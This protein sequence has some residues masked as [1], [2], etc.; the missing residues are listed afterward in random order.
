MICCRRGKF[1][2]TARNIEIR[3]SAYSQS[4]GK[5]RSLPSL[6]LGHACNLAIAECIDEKL[7]I[8]PCLVT[9][10]MRKIHKEALELDSIFSD[11]LIN[12]FLG[13]VCSVSLI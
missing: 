8:L 9:V 7:M 3:V 5:Y 11:R 1:I 6:S 2:Y 10:R 4:L 13:R 12:S